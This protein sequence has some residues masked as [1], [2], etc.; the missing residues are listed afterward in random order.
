ML[1]SPESP[2]PMTTRRG[3]CFE[4]GSIRVREHQ[5]ASGIRNQDQ[6]RGVD[7]RSESRVR[8]QTRIRAE[9]P[10]VALAPVHALIFSSGPLQLEVPARPGSRMQVLKVRSGLSLR[11][12]LGPGHESHKAASATSEVTS[13]ESSYARIFR[14]DTAEPTTNVAEDHGDV[15]HL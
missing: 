5:E 6:A 7:I 12:S 13:L 11:R 9:S 10:R 1:Q 2:S 8:V 4:S 15:P 3:R 14:D